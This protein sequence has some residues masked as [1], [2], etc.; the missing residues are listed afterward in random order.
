MSAQRIVIVYPIFVLE[1][2]KK[3]MVI[4]HTIVSEIMIALQNTN[5]W[6]IQECVSTLRRKKDVKIIWI[7]EFVEIALV[8]VAHLIMGVH[9]IFVLL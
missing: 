8:E 3:T 4:V 9:T 6:V 7:V 5:V 2:L 1:I